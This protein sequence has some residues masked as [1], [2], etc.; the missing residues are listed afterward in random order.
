MVFS[1]NFIDQREPFSSFDPPFQG[2]QHT[3][4]PDCV[5]RPWPSFP[6]GFFVLFRFLWWF[7]CRQVFFTHSFPLVSIF[8]R[9]LAPAI[10]TRLRSVWLVLAASRLACA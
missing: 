9:P 10:V 3:I 8:L 1:R 5:F 2:P 4:S 6:Q 7:H